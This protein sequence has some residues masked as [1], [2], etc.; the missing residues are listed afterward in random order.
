MQRTHG[1]ARVMSKRGLC[2]RSQA[3]A[4]IRA[5]RVNVAGKSVR[6]PES[7]TD[8]GADIQ[9]DAQ[10]QAANIA[11]VY[12]ALNKPRGLICSNADERGR[13][14][15]RAL[16]DGLAVPHLSAVGR[17]D[18]ASEGL[19]L[20][21]NDS[22][23]AAGITEPA[24]ALPKIYHVQ[25]SKV[26]NEN[27]LAQLR[28]GIDDAGERLSAAAVHILRSGG[29]TAWLECTLIEGKNR[30]LRRMCAAIDAEVLRLIRVQI[31]PLVLGELAKGQW[32]ALT[33]AEIV[34][35]R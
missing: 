21:T 12:F 20:M 35:L 25:I 33:D 17:L 19:L 6:D 27:E 31:G 2:S 24:R 3:E 1:L 15:V 22:T 16:F 10:T 34:S 4:L 32:R 28:T 8:L 5:G 9:I 18:Q 11:R 29:K 23:W 7:R 26:P 30:Q 14:T 13:N